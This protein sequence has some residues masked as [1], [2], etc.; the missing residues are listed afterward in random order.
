M[1][2]L[3]YNFPAALESAAHHS[4]TQ[5]SSLLG[6][7]TASAGTLVA[8]SFVPED[9]TPAGALY[10]AALV[11]MA[12][13]AIAPAAAAIRDP[14]AL[15]RAENVIVL[16]PI[17]WLLL[18]LLQGL[19]PMQ[20]I[21]S[22]PIDKAFI[23]IGVFVVAVWLGVYR[24]PWKVPRG[25][26]R[27]VSQELP[28]N[29]YFFL[30]VAAFVLGMLS[31]LIPTNFDVVKMFSYLGDTRWAAPW[32]RG[33]LGGWDAFADQLQY[34]GYLLPAL[35]VILSRRSGWG[36][37]KTLF[38][39]GMSILMMIF[40]AQS[41]ARRVVGVVFGAA[42]IS[43]LLT[44]KQLRI[45]HMLLG[46]AA[47]AAL[48]FALQIMLEYRNL[49]LAT[50]AE[51]ADYE[52]VLEEDSV[53]VDDN[54]YR[55]SQV[56]ELI[57]EYH[58]HVYQDY[59]IWVAVRPIPRVFWPGKPVDPGFDLASALGRKEISLS[60]SVIGEF[61][62]AAG[63][64]GIALGGWFYGRL[65]GMASRLLAGPA[66]LGVVLMYGILTMALFTGV[67]SMLDLVLVNYA[68]LGWFGLS[69]AIIYLRGQKVS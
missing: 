43:W 52:P 65:C 64:I 19:Y 5:R 18:D 45:R 56:I 53:R 21:G 62:M 69:R 13:L 27:A 66:N 17:Y 63:F 36:D 38:S 50:L 46:A 28:P 42:L 11:M 54:F 35:T 33:Q 41:G 32:I 15:L 23:S 4:T 51:R 60:I 29:I 26:M 16:A 37:V 67:R 57:P 61:Y 31:F 68:T 7:A 12:S 49:G 58:P 22:E 30:C 8:L 55:L 25:L 47:A 9:P 2:S 10:F 20:A 34:F 40:L 48:L 6:I 59:V 39:I 14:K 1:E 24:R 3:A 44:Q